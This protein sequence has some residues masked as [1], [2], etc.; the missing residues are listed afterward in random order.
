MAGHISSFI[1]DHGPSLRRATTLTLIVGGTTTTTWILGWQSQLPIFLPLLCAS[2][3][4]EKGVSEPDEPSRKGLIYARVSTDEQEEGIDRQINELRDLAERDGIEIAHEPIEDVGKSGREFDRAGLQK[5]LRLAQRDDVTDVLVE[6]T[7]RLGRRAPQTLSMI[8]LI[9]CECDVTIV[10]TKGEMDTTRINGLA[11][12]ALQTIIS[13]IENRNR[14]HRLLSGKIN[15]FKNRNWPS[16]FHQPPYGYDEDGNWSDDDAP[17]KWIKINSR[18]KVVVQDLY[19]YFVE[20]AGIRSGYADTKRYIEGKYS[21]SLDR[22]K[23]KRILQDPVYLGKPTVR[24]ETLG[25]DGEE[26][27]VDDDSLRMIDEELFEKAQSKIQKIHDL[28]STS[29]EKEIID[30]D[31]LL[32]EYGVEPLLS[33]VDC[34]AVCCPEDDCD[35][36]MRKCGQKTLNDQ[37]LGEDDGKTVHDWECRGCNRRKKFPNTWELYRLQH[38]ID[39]M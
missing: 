24:G 25:D 17:E 33:I 37:W 38:D 9:Q 15:A 3:N 6:D 34:V 29:L 12:A 16:W 28:H 30:L 36:L 14:A 13:D 21:E 23:L 27:V 1:S 11:M 18:E 10:T 35:G 4:S 31:V 22:H 26:G 39:Q 7:D 19:E 8:D 2:Y 20:T 5:L 32:A